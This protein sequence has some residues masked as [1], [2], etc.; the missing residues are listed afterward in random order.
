MDGATTRQLRLSEDDHSYDG[1][2]VDPDAS[3]PSGGRR[4]LQFYF[5]IRCRFGY[6]VWDKCLAACAGNSFA[7]RLAAGSGDN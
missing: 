4:R 7:C 5:L 3:F 6:H 1:H 2:R